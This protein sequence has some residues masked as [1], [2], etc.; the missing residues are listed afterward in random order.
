M[1]Y[2]ALRKIQRQEQQLA[3]RRRRCSDMTERL[4]RANEGQCLLYQEPSTED[5]NLLIAQILELI[6]VYSSGEKGQAYEQYRVLA[7]TIFRWPRWQYQ[8]LYRVVKGYND[9]LAEDCTGL[10]FVLV[11]ILIAVLSSQAPES[12]AL[13]VEVQ[14]FIVPLP[15]VAAMTLKVPDDFLYEWYI[16]VILEGLNSQ[17]VNDA[18]AEYLGQSFKQS[19]TDRRKLEKLC[20][21]CETWF[22]DYDTYLAGGRYIPVVHG[23]ILPSTI[24]EEYV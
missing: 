5:V 20:A 1:L 14:G 15:R 12:G 9:T 18:D 17:D 8:A 2:T 3:E 21:A 22:K 13:L 16:M 4:E 11:H 6:E 19:L 10:P 24:V 23:F 7:Y